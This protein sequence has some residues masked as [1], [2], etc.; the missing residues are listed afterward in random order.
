MSFK[1]NNFMQDYSL[2]H[3]LSIPSLKLNVANKRN[4]SILQVF[5]R[6][7]GMETYSR[8]DR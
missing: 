1:K 2:S 4:N 5:T 8:Q 7:L 6:S 3:F